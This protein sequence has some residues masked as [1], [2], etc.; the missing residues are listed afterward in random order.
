M[1]GKE[2]TIQ[3]RKP[4]KFGTD[5]WRAIIA[6]DFT[7]DNVRLCAQGVAN[8]ANAKG[9]AGKGIV[10]GYDNRFASEDFAAATA[11]VLCGNG[12]K[13]FLCPESAPTPVVSYGTVV[14]GAGGGIVITA[15][16]NPAA[17]NGFKYKTQDGASAPVEIATTIEQNIA[18][19][20]ELGVIRRASLEEATRSGLLESFDI[21]PLY[22]AHLKGLVDVPRL[23]KAKLKLG[24][25]PMWGCGIG[26]MR[27]LLAGGNL[28]LVE[29]NNHVNPAF[30]GMKQPEPIGPNLT[31]L[32]DAVRRHSL[33]VGLATDG[34]ADRFGAVDGAGNALTTLQIYALLCLY[35]LEIRKERG[36]IV[37]TLTQTSMAEKLAKLFDVPIRETKIGFKYVAPIMIAENA[38]M[39]GEESGGY[40]FRGH[41]P[42]RDGI[43]AGLYF[44][45]LMVSTGK[46]PTQ[47]LDYLTE[48]VGPH[49]FDRRDIHFPADQRARIVET[50]QKAMPQQ[51]DGS[52]VTRRDTTDGFKYF[53]DDGA[54]LL[55]RFSGTE[56][57]LRVYAEAS[58]PERVQRL[59]DEGIKLAGV[60]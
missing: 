57:L 50:I 33:D 13:V 40:G 36:L 53:L 19:L 49:S 2:E 38:V 21:K 44:L 51:L 9:I 43:L 31:A 18:K 32:S 15:S 58:S 35:L 42:E 39:G 55:V 20:S 16:H 37:K 14:K 34:D 29:V 11:E 25:D 48:K 23:R 59:L 3:A 1:I 52:K 45:D 26:Y 27:D 7:F 12:V 17:W 10:I 54:W 56:P 4:I 41:V 24:I 47:L 46:N 22:L 60:R 5:G 6:D 8:Y 30:P 28:E